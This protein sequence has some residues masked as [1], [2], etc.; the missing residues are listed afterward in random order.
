MVNMNILRDDFQYD[1]IRDETYV[2]ETNLSKKRHNRNVWNIKELSS[3]ESIRNYYGDR[4]EMIQWA[5][6][7]NRTRQWLQENYP[8]LMI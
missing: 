8:E 3:I 4:L 5:E 2:K 1:L 7:F 6:S